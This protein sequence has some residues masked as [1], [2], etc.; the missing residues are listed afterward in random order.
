VTHI[1]PNDCLCGKW[2]LPG[3]VTTAFDVPPGASELLVTA[4]TL[5]DARLIIGFTCPHCGAKAEAPP[6]HVQPVSTKRG[7]AN[8]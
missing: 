7:G 6:M 2:S 5:I 3:S 4:L 1:N 8:G